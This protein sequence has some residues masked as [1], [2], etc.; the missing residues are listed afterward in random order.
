M[1]A[2][3]PEIDAESYRGELL[4]YCYRYFGCYSEAADAVQE[5]MLRAWQHASGFDGRSSVRT[6]LYRI[7][8]NIC[9]DMKKA[10]QRR[11][12]PA[13]LSSPGRVP[14]D[15]RTLTT[16]P[17]ATWIG[18]VWD[19]YLDPADTVA[20]RDSVRLAFVTALQLLPPRQRVVLILRDV[21]SWSAQE[22]ADLLELSVAAVNSALARARRTI[23]D[24]DPGPTATGTD[25]QQ[26][27]ADYVAAF[28]AYDVDRLVRLLAEDAMFS[29]PPYSLWLQGS[30]EIERWWRGPGQICRNSRTIITNANRQPSVAVYH[31]LG[32]G[33]WEPFALHVLDVGEHRI[34]AITHFMGP[35]AFGEFGLPAEILE[36]RS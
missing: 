2:T 8:T 34:A 19:G 7:A 22:C 12:L 3:V 33:R 36:T 32:T 13:D 29:M 30:A 24:R 35:R 11:A 9:L 25:D 21:L 20:Q 23:A 4:G 6:W 27:L 28:E 1:T 5:T 15:P 14:D 31:D 17:D 26:L 16:L 18:P 10:P